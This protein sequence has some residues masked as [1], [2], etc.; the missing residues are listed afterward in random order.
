MSHRSITH[1]RARLALPL[2]ALAA[3][4]GRRAAAQTLGDR[5]ELH[6]AVNAA[7]GRASNLGVFGIPKTGT[8]DYR[9]VTL[10]GR[11][12]IDDNDQIVAQI[13][14]RRLGTSPLS[15]AISDVTMQWAYYQHRAKDFTFKVGRNP[16]PRGL[17]NEVRYIGTVLPFFR[18][19]L[20]VQQESFD[21]IDGV[22][23][24]Y[25]HDLFAGIE[26]EQ[27]AFYGGSEFRAIATTSTGQ[28]VR[29]A[30]TENMFGAQGYLTFPVAG[31][32]FGAY[33]ARY[34]FNQSSGRGYRSN[35]IFS[36]ESTVDR[37]KL[38]TEVSRITGYVPSNDNRGGYVQGTFRIVDRF[39]VAGQ[40]AWINRKLYPKNP[41]LNRMY[42]EVRTKGVSGIFNLTNNA[43]IKLEHHWRTGYSFDEPV[44]VL[45]AQTATS[46][47]I[48]PPSKTRY[49]LA[50]VAATF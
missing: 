1:G 19:P 48:A 41:D 29:I 16:L 39:S 35:W 9:V 5:L 49:F 3:F 26:Y 33:G 30:R 28:Q 21:A 14:N 50:S 12:K 24:S 31:L 15:G 10:Q 36:G 6:G 37:L 46:V 42:P 17:Y 8:S 20:E 34:E 47:T 22:V 27:H 43:V 7:Y 4:G 45:T 44:S 40:D 18:P 11:F 13:F 23:A 2:L 38:T 25:H 32:R